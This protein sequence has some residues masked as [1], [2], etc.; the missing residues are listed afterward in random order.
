VALRTGG[1]S[2][3][4]RESEQHHV[5]DRQEESVRGVDGLRPGVVDELVN[6]RLHEDV[7]AEDRDASIHG[8]RA[9]GWVRW[10]PPVQ[11]RCGVVLL[12]YVDHDHAVRD[13]SSQEG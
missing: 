5:S 3:P 6:E 7:A 11:A 2:A 12:R 4:G 13:S 1:D 8:I 10:S 9:A